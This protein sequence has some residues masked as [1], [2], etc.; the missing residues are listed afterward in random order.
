MRRCRSK[1]WILSLSPVG[2]GMGKIWRCRSLLLV[3][4][5]GLEPLTRLSKEGNSPIPLKKRGVRRTDDI[6]A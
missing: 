3:R 5:V 1:V 2:S 4:M 6:I